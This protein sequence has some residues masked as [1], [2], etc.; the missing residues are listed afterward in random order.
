[1]SH[2]FQSCAHCSGIIV[3]TTL[4]QWDMASE[5][6]SSSGRLASRGPH[7]VIACFTP[8]FAFHSSLFALPLEGR[9]ISIYFWAIFPDIQKSC[10]CLSH[11][12]SGW[13]TNHYHTRCSCECVITSAPGLLSSFQ[14]H[15]VYFLLFLLFSLSAHMWK[16]HV[17]VQQQLFQGGHWLIDFLLLF[18]SVQ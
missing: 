18:F 7:A 2:V 1:M 4:H 3:D 16:Q 10:N 13:P 5:K 9:L 6:M 14:H 8:P 17:T 11:K 12:F 15:S